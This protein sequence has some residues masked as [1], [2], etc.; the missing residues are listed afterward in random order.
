[1]AKPKIGNCDYKQIIKF[2][3]T[4]GIDITLS[5]IGIN[6]ENIEEIVRRIDGSLDAD[7]SFKDLSQVKKILEES[8]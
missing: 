3:D 5:D 4:I 8:L 2:M 6:K 7:P 1:M